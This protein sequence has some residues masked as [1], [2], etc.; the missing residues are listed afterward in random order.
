MR[1]E[2]HVRPVVTLTPESAISAS[3]HSHHPALTTVEN[4]MC[5]SDSPPAAR[6]VQGAVRESELPKVRAVPSSSVRTLHARAVSSRLQGSI[7]GRRPP[8]QIVHSPVAS[9]PVKR[10]PTSF[11]TMT[12]TMTTT[13][14]FTPSR[15]ALFI[16]V[17]AVAA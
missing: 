11:M 17:V 2:R 12:A 5:V 1:G 8:S 3:V 9:T 4:K 16:T 15:G 10:H 7:Q 13:M 14:T 6:P